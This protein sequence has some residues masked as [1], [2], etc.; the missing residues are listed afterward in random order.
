MVIAFIITRFWVALSKLNS[1][2][3]EKKEVK[4]EAITP[5]PPIDRLINVTLLQEREISLSNELYLVSLRLLL[6]CIVVSKPIVSS[7]M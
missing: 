7:R 1:L 2:S 4:K 5:I 3:S 6:I